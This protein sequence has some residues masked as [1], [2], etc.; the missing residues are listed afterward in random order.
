MNRTNA[1]LV[2]LPNEI[3]LIILNNLNNMD[4]LYSLI[5]TG[6]ERLELIAQDKIFTNTLNFVSTDTDKICSIDDSM[7]DQFCIHILPKIHYNVRCLVIES[8]AMERILF[9]GDYP[10]LTQL[11][12][13]NFNQDIVS[14]YFT[15][16][17]LI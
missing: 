8:M 9:S 6:I 12:I 10:N 17:Y 1:R 5:S 2:D 14:Q 11:K 4:V 3:L 16:K 13:F 7:L 15:G